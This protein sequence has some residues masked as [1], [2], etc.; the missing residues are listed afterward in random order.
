M[1]TRVITKNVIDGKSA[2]KAGLIVQNH[3]LN[4]E[5]PI[6][7]KSTIRTAFNI[8]VIKSLSKQQI[9]WLHIYNKNIHEQ[10]HLQTPAEMNQANSL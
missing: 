4:E 3:K 6:A 10:L 8:E 2:I 9:L 5:F 1:R 7:P